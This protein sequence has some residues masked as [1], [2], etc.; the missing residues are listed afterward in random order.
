MGGIDP[1]QPRPIYLAP[2]TRDARQSGQVG[3]TEEP[4][5][6]LI[7]SLGGSKLAHGLYFANPWFIGT[8]KGGRSVKT[9]NCLLNNL[10]EVLLYIYFF[11]LI[12]P[13]CHPH[14]LP[15]GTLSLGSCACILIDS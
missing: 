14:S 1:I 5:M 13:F 8:G 6:G 3:S 7:K 4:T 9:L 12:I 11:L 2:T 15:L 10:V